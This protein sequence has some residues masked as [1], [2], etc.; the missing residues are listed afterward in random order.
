MVDSG[1]GYRPDLARVVGA[2]PSEIL[3][4]I[5]SSTFG[6]R[7]AKDSPVSY[8]K[9]RDAIAER[10]AQHPVFRGLPPEAVSAL[11][12]EA[13]LYASSANA[14][15]YTA[16]HGAALASPS[17]P[18]SRSASAPICSSGRAGRKTAF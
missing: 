17:C 16:A 18:C 12:A 5:G 9:R 10:L 8:Q 2:R 7:I 13:T 14:R 11:V 4:I 6:R 1:E 15:S 3:A